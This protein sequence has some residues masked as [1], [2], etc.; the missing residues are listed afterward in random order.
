[1]KGTEQEL[2]RDEGKKVEMGQSQGNY[3]GTVQ[4]GGRVEEELDRDGG[5]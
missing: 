2:C 3:A 1:V 4:G 5:N